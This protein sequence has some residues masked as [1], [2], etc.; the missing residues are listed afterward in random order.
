MINYS[1]LLPL[2]TQTFTI[3]KHTQKQTKQEK[4]NPTH[5]AFHSRSDQ[6]LSNGKKILVDC[7]QNRYRIFILL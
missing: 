4:T 5:I 6:N 7:L 2:P 1:C 3:K